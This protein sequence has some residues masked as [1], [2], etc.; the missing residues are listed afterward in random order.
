MTIPLVATCFVK[1]HHGLGEKSSPKSVGRSQSVWCIRCIEVDLYIIGFVTVRFQRSFF[2][3][4]LTRD[5]MCGF[6][7]LFEDALKGI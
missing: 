5:L 1:F 7:I 4:A 6:L 2:V 3:F